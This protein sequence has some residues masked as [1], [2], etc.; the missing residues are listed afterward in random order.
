[1]TPSTRQNTPGPTSCGGARTSPRSK[2]CAARSAARTATAW[3]PN[4]R[5]RPW[6]AADA[7]TRRATAPQPASGPTGRSDTGTR[8]APSSDGPRLDA[9]LELSIKVSGSPRSRAWGR[10]GD[11][12]EREV[13][14]RAR[15]VPGRLVLLARPDDVEVRP[16]LVEL[17][18]A[19]AA[20]LLDAVRVRAAVLLLGRRGALAVADDAV[21]VEV[22]EE[23]AVVH[24]PVQKR[25][26][27]RRTVRHARHAQRHE[28]L[29]RQRKVR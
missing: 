8:A 15:G 3:R 11:V 23:A 21:D 17:V 16:A 7:A 24:E 19:G 2:S 28:R 5:N 10:S 14:G 27:Q 12:S 22:H 26:R 18:E 1:M 4:R 29:W 6:P 9:D 13:H 20:A 25:L